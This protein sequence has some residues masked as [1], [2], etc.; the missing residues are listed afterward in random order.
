MKWGLV[1][2]GVIVISKIAIAQTNTYSTPDPQNA[3]PSKINVESPNPFKGFGSP[4]KH[5]SALNIDNYYSPKIQGTAEVGNVLLLRGLFG[6]KRH[7][8]RATLPFVSIATPDGYK[9]GIGN[10]NIFDIIRLTNDSSRIHFGIGPLVS[11]PTASSSAL[12]V[13]QWQFGGS[14]LITHVT[15]SG[16]ITGGL[17]TYRTSVFGNDSL[18]NGGGYLT[19]QP[20]LVL[21]MGNGLYGR[22]MGATCIFDFNNKKVLIPIGIGI[23]QVFKAGNT[24]VNI[25]IEPAFTVYSEGNNLPAYQVLIG[26]YF[27][28]LKDKK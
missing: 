16:I 8:V 17:A 26:L 7:M 11:I 18:Q 21:S 23:G 14:T 1:F 24:I 5:S 28:W 3:V 19:F 20:A 10:I 2:I 4:W 9:S 25:F 12:G 13:D 27:F 6:T 22:S 15:A